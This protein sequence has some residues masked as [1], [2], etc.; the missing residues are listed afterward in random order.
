MAVDVTLL[1]SD[2]NDSEL[3]G[4]ETLFFGK[5]LSYSSI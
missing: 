2:S 5:A 3:L 4:K 1:V